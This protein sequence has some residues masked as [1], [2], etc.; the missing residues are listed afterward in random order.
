MHPQGEVVGV[1][2]RG[3]RRAQEH[4][5]G[6]RL[7]C[8]RAPGPGRKG[9]LLEQHRG[10]R[11]WKRGGELALVLL[12]HGGGRH[13]G[14]VTE[15]QGVPPVAG[16]RAELLGEVGKET[17]AAVAAGA[18]LAEARAV[19]RGVEPRLKHAVRKVACREGQQMSFSKC[20][21]CKAEM[22]GITKCGAIRLCPVFQDE[23]DN[24][25]NG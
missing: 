19:L 9:S 23:H 4:L 16:Q 25:D 20:V 18:V 8:D 13:G 5:R 2:A 15:G 7:L 3:P 11:D 22:G 12:F 24:F 6:A 21:L 17:D 1:F 14:G 10:W